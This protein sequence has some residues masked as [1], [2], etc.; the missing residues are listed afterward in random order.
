MIISDYNNFKFKSHRQA[1]H[2]FLVSRENLSYLDQNDYLDE[3][4]LIC[5]KGKD[6]HAATLKA[7][8]S[9]YNTRNELEKKV[10]IDFEIYNEKLRYIARD[11]HKS[12]KLIAKIISK[13]TEDFIR[14]LIRFDLIDNDYGS[15]R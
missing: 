3:S 6:I 2:Y 14:E 7:L 4:E 9:F 12:E 1:I 11:N 15:R 10:F 5:W 8:R 13:N